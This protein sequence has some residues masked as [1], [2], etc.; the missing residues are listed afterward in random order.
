MEESHVNSSFDSID[1]EIE[2]ARNRYAGILDIRR[3]KYGYGLFLLKKA[4]EGDLVFKARGLDV[5]D[6][7]HS[8]SIQTNWTRHTFMDLPARFINH[9][10]DA[11]CGIRDN[12]IGAFDFFALRDINID[13]ELSW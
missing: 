9:N 12:E 13:E 2:D 3:T 4:K 5:S 8:H 6:K 10:C 1:A 7:R 11:N